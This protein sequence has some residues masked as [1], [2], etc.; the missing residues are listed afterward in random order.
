[1][2]ASSVVALVT[3]LVGQPADL[4]PFV[5]D[6]EESL[7]VYYQ[8]PDPSLGPKLLKELLKK[9]N[10]DHP[11]FT[12][13]DHSLHV[14]AA[15]LGDVAAGK[16]KIVREYETAFADASLAGRRVI[17]RALTNCGDGE[18]VKRIDQWLA[19]GRYAGL[20]PDL[21]ALKTHLE[22]PAPKHARDRP[23]REPTD[24]DFLWANFFVTGEY[25]PVARILDVLDQ[26]D[27]AETAVLKRVALWSLASN[28][29]QHPKLVE[30]VRGHAQ[31][32]P[33]GSRTAVREAM[34]AVEP[35]EAVV[36]KWVS[37]DD[38]KVPLEFLRDGTAKVGFVKEKGEWLIATG[39]FTVT[40]KGTV[41]CSV[42]H[43][44]STLL[45]SWTVKDGTLIGSRGPKPQVR[46]VKIKE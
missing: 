45:G 42:H 30:L 13:N 16:P 32:R 26:P 33:A 44:G 19:D 27:A 41:I 31:D 5:K 24:L 21:T 8:A 23:A 22:N 37:D 10:L 35:M 12:M 17:V 11:W 43:K 25:A 38:E 18:T 2:H 14:I 28:L 29:Q 39:R 46:W 40:D 34:A 20:R 7:T 3:A 9:E 15:L 36:G 4:P 1:V 6:H